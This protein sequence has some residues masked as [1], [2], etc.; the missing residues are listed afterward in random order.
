MGVYSA[1]ASAVN[2]PDVLHPNRGLFNYRM[3]KYL[4]SAGTKLDVVSPRPFA[5]PVGPHSEYGTLPAVEEWGQYAIHHP[6]FWYLLPKR[7]FYAASGESFARRVPSYLERTFEVPDV[8]HAC[9]IYLDGY[10]VLP[11]VRDHDL[12]LFVVA[13]GTIL[14]T[15]DDQPPGVRSR[16]LETLREATGVL[17]VSDALAE[18]ARRHASP[19]K[20]STVPIGADPDHFPVERSTEIRRELGI[21]ADATVVLFVGR[22]SRE[23]GVGDVVDL[24]PALEL[25]DVEFVFV[26]NGGDLRSELTRSLLENGYSARNVLWDLS[27]VAVR[28]WFAIADLLL[29]PSHMEG[30]PTVVYEAMASR[31]AV[32]ASAVGGV[33]EQVEDGETGMLVPP[34]DVPALREALE[35][36]ATDREALADMGA[37]GYERLRRNDWTWKRHVERVQDL[38]RAAIE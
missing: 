9:H 12:P 16:V 14:N 38:H 31:T 3:L 37:K 6:K 36:L 7:L 30:R 26:G 24:L 23:K 8:V 20:V 4:D 35:S 11:Y 33:P 13:H 32:L 27:P 28:R 21:D 18:K 19:S 10:G 5:P 25:E 17:C 34:R 1:I 29:L 2:H 15:L 22:Y